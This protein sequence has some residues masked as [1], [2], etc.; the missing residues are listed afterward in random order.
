M[1]KKDSSKS[2]MIGASCKLQLVVLQRLPEGK[3][4]VRQGIFCEASC[5]VGCRAA[6]NRVI[7]SSCGPLGLL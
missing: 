4:V 7:E 3:N 2:I 6:A 1:Q 5:T